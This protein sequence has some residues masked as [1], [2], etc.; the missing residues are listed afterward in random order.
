MKNP[1][2]FLV[3]LVIAAFSNI[4]LAQNA[5]DVISAHRLQRLD[6]GATQTSRLEG[7]T[8]IQFWASWCVSC[9][10]TMETVVEAAK[11][12]SFNFVTVSLDEDPAAARKYLER[13]GELSGKL[14]SATLVDTRQELAT[15]LQIAAVPT[16]LA[17]GADGKILSRMSG[18]VSAKD[19]ERIRR[20]LDS[21]R[22][23]G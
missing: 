8:I 23:P 10:K 1:V 18:H 7:P 13:A 3:A 2:K 22:H 12:G 19:L 21:S 20:E 4:A 5:F 17:V 9:R 11:T 15:T 14:V 16:V 6:T